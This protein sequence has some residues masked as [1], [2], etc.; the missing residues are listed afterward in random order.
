MCV[1]LGEEEGGEGVGRFGCRILGFG[2][3][4]R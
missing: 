4:G 2:D 1:E 3:C